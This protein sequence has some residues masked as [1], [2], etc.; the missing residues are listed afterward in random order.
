MVT[1][2]GFAHLARRR[3]GIDFGGEALSKLF[4]GRRFRHATDRAAEMRSSTGKAFSRAPSDARMIC[5]GEPQAR[6]R[7]MASSDCAAVLRRLAPR[8][9]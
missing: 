2:A 6:R 9:G 4:E 1:A 3:A 5:S 8:V 7:V